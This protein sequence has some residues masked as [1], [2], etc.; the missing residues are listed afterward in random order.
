MS[1]SDSAALVK[2]AVDIVDVV[3]QV[4]PLRRVGNRHL[5]LC[6]FHQEKTPSFQV[7]AE[8]QLYYC[9]GCQSGGDVLS[10]VMKQRNVSFSEALEHL[11]ERYHIALPG[12]DSGYGSGPMAEAARKEREQVYAILQTAAD[13]FYGQLHHSEAGSIARSYIEQ[14]GLP[15]RLVEEE[16]LGFAPPQWDGLFQH[17]KKQAATNIELGLTAGLLARSSKDESRIYDRFRNR[18]IFPILNEQ[19]QVIAFGGRSLSKEAQDEPKYL[20]SP[21]T[22]VYHKGKTLYQM[23]RA[24]E[25]CRQG[26]HVLLVE[27]YM[28]LLAFHAQGFYRVVATLGTALTSSQIRL[29]SRI[30]DEVTLAYDGDEAGERAMLRALPLFLAEELPVSCICFPDGMDPDDFLKTEGMASFETLLGQRRDLGMYAID[31]TLETWDGGPVGKTKVIAELQPIF[32]GVRQPVLRSE[33]LRRVSERLSLTQDVLEDQIRHEK[34]Q[35]QK[36]VAPRRLVSPALPK[37][38]QQESLEESI[39]RL[40]IKYPELI[41]EVKGSGAAGFFQEPPLKTIA[42]VLMQ[43]PHPPQGAFTAAGV[44]DLL[45]DSGQKELFTRLRLDP[46]ETEQPQLHLKDRLAKLFEREVK[47]E[48]LDLRESLRQAEQQGNQIQVRYFL[49]QLQQNL[50]SAKKRVRATPEN[51]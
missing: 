34:R 23:G 20:N 2:Q 36:S 29:L 22:P 49:A 17:L 8:N 25:A 28:D 15:A 26:R 44:Y 37:L 45:Q 40:M 50:R 18:L 1:A 39:L 24:R 10:F 5:G 33:Y 30:A 31:K 6:P 27:G 35:V 12:K 46:A 51:V 21:E 41:E 4:V 13:F 48:R 32:E 3:S 43:A 16:R 42:E 11:A 14:R 38:A 19:K 7:D 9:F 47:Q